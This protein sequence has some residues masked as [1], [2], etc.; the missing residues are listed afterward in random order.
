MEGK[1]HNLWLK[2]TAALSAVAFG[3]CL[4]MAVA[5][6]SGAG[7]PGCSGSGGCGS[8]LSSRWAMVLGVI[9]VSALAAG[10]YLILTTILAVLAIDAAK[11]REKLL[12]AA[13]TILSGAIAGSAAKI[14]DPTISTAS[15]AAISFL[16]FI[17]FLL[18]EN[19]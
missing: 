17:F 6:L 7:M 10:L 3:L 1:R 11:G 12:W 4:W 19:F 13:A 15:K 9:P 8:A 5:T 14:R 2:V 16:L 18:L